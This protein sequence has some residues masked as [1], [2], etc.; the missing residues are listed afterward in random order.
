QPGSLLLL[1]RPLLRG[2]GDVHGGES[3]LGA[4]LRGGAVRPPLDPE[5]GRLLAQRGRPGSGLRH[6]RGC[7]DPRDPL[8]LPA[9]LPEV[10]TELDGGT[11]EPRSR[12]RAPARAHDAA[13]LDAG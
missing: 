6:G 12:P 13:R 8:P 5:G 3:L 2:A 4:L 7:P 1:V 9:D 10:D 11:L